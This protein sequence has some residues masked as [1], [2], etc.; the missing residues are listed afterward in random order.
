MNQVEALYDVLPDLYPLPS[1]SSSPQTLSSDN[2][3]SMPLPM[4]GDSHLALKGQPRPG[5][6]G[7]LPRVHALSLSPCWGPLQLLLRRRDHYNL[8]TSLSP[9]SLC[10]LPECSALTCFSR[11]IETFK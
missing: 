6:L 2:S 1:F 4:S 11:I 7:S 9:P 3:S 8:L 5:P 10:A